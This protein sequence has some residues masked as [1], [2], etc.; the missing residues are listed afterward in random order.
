MREW[1]EMNEQ[2]Q[3]IA[4]AEACGKNVTAYRFMYRTF[5]KQDWEESPHYRTERE[6]NG[7]RGYESNWRETKSGETVRSYHNTEN[8]PRDLNA[9]AEAEKTLSTIEHELF[10]GALYEICERDERKWISATAS[11]RAEAFLRAKGLW[12]E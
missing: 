1:G 3:R 6:A 7:Q 4:I 5:Y 2:E 10:R 12:K 9:I 8:Y 11:Q